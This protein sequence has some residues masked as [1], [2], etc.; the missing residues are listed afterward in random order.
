[1]RKVL[2]AVFVVVLVASLLPTAI[3]GQTSKWQ[4]QPDTGLPGLHCHDWDTDY[5]TLADDWMCEGGE[6]TDIHWWGNYEGE[7]RGDGIM[8]FHLSIHVDD[9]G[10]LPGPEV[11]FADVPFDAIT[12]TDSGLVNSEGNIIYKYEYFLD[13]PFPQVQGER[14]WLDIMAISANH[15]SPPLWRWQE[16][17]RTGSP[18]LCGAAERTSMY[19]W[20]T[21]VW[22]GDLY[23][24]MA[25]EITS[26]DQ[27]QDLD[28]GDAPEGASAM[29]YPSTMTPGSF[30]TCASCGPASH[31][32]HGLGWARFEFH[33]PAGPGRDAES[34]GN[35]GLCPTCFPTYDDDECFLDGDAG[36]MFPEPYTID[37]GGAVVPCPAGSGTPLRMTGQSAVWGTDIDIRVVN[38][39][40]VDG[41]VN[42]LMDWDQDGDWGTLAE[43][44]LRDFMVP[45]GY[46]G[47]LSGLFP[48]SFTVGSNPGYVWARFSITEQ[49]VLVDGWDGSGV[50]E[51]GETEDYLLRIDGDEELDFGDALDLYPMMQGYPTMLERDGARHV[52]GGPWLGDSSDA[53]DAEQN[54]QPEPLALGDDN[55]DANDDEDG[56]QIP[57]LLTGQTGSATVEV[58]GGGGYV[59]A[60]IDFDLN[61][62]WDADELVHSAWLGNGIHTITFP[63]NPD[64]VAGQTF[65]RFRISTQGGLA[66]TGLASDGEVEDHV[67]SVQNPLPFDNVKW[68]QYPDTT[69]NGIDVSF[70]DMDTM[71][72]LVLADD[73]ECTEPGILTDVHFWASWLGDMVGDPMNVMV[74]LS[75][76][77]D[78]PVGPGGSDPANTYSKPD[79][80]LWE[81]HYAPGQVLAE[82]W[83]QGDPEW[84]W[85]PASGILEPSADSMIWLYSIDIDPATAFVQTG[86]VEEPVIYWLDISVETPE[87]LIGWK[88][89]QWPNHYMDDAVWSHAMTPDSWQEMRYHIGHPFEGDSIDLA[90]G[91]TFQEAPDLVVTQK[92]EQLLAPMYDTYD[93]TYTV[94]NLGPGSAGASDTGIYIDGSWVMDNTCPTF[95]PSE[96]YTN[97]VGPFTMTGANDTIRVCADD[98]MQVVELDET[99]N[100]LQNVQPAC[101]DWDVNCDHKCSIGDVVAIGLKWGLSG[102]PGWIREDAND[103]GEVTIGDVVFV[104]LYWG[105]AW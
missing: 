60:W 9:G 22:P 89:R 93:I 102:P 6:V 38:N 16:H 49:P 84:W 74:H 48:P 97:T 54:G 64:A 47:P 101:P 105:M 79:L 14:Y 18:I 29:A 70:T 44:V 37:A 7:I 31:I 36:L 57:V 43:H 59:D 21:V 39:M 56:V 53:S 17:Q 78:D 98:N 86:T 26:E 87:G 51:D 75:I 68:V 52:I 32:E 5:I 40:P 62:I 82:P 4:Q 10:C 15:A 34:D 94:Q 69:Q 95:A 80:L 46:I 91:L 42:V 33:P 63:L 99:N 45:M 8:V 81:G 58:S 35:A 13:T 104:G 66:P 12:E 11:W 41:Y 55:L 61:F 23:G 65:A 77:S 88:T 19:Y 96:S 27:P 100:C 72:P 28:Y 76:H 20:T 30:P 83:W 67:V 73:F 25:F 85:D 24:D 3:L 90:F 92:S 50:F 1:M 2:A 103:N 71:E